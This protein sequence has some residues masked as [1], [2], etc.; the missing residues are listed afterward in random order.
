VNA[1]VEWPSR[2][3]TTFSGTPASNSNGELH[4]ALERVVDVLRNARD[5]RMAGAEI[6]DI[7][8]RLAEGNGKE[9]RLRPPSRS[10]SSSVP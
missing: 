6:A 1:G 7:A 4:T 9:T 3:L 5:E 10:A 2:S 8:R